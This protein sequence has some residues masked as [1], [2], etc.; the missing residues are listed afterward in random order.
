MSSLGCFRDT[1]VWNGEWLHCGGRDDPQEDITEALKTSF[2]FIDKAR[3]SDEKLLVFDEEGISRSAAVLMYWMMRHK[4]ASVKVCFSVFPETSIIALDLVSRKHCLFC[5]R[6]D[7]QCFLTM[8]LCAACWNKSVCCGKLQNL[9]RRDPI[10]FPPSRLP[11]L[12]VTWG[13]KPVLFCAS[14]LDS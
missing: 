1:K 14:V 10:M 3:T 11:F 4:N 13:E 9:V 12:R 8:V 2:R 6:F 7:L 5:A